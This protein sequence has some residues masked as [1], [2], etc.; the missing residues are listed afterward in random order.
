MLKLRL[1]RTVSIITALSLLFTLLTATIS[2]SAEGITEN[3]I[4]NGD[5]ESMMNDWSPRKGDAIVST[6]D[7]VHSGNFS[8]K[9]SL[10]E[11][12]DVNPFTTQ[13]VKVIPNTEYILSAWVK[14]TGAPAEALIPVD[15]YYVDETGARNYLANHHSWRKV[16]GDMVGSWDGKDAEWHQIHNRFTTAPTCNSLTVFLR[17]YT[18]TV[19]ATVYFDDVSLARTGEPEVASID[20]DQVFYYPDH[21]EDGVATVTV[22]E[23]FEEIASSG[24]VDFAFKDGAAALKT[25]QNTA[26]KNG[27]ASFVYPMS[28]LSQKQHEYTIEAVVK[29]RS[30]AVK[31]NLAAR[32]F[33]YDRP[34]NVTK[35][36]QYIKDG[37]RAYPF[38]S[39]SLVVERDEDLLPISTAGFSVT[40]GGCFTSGEK[41]LAQLD[42]VH[43]QGMMLIVQMYLNML[44]PG[45]SNNEALT[46]EI[47]TAIKDHPALFAYSVMDEPSGRANVSKDDMINTYRI[48]RDI[49][50]AHPVYLTENYNFIWGGKYC[51]ILGIDPYG[52]PETKTAAIKTAAAQEAVNYE[53]PVYSMIQA[54]NNGNY[55]PT[56]N[57]ARLSLFQSVLTGATGLSF[58][59]FLAGKKDEGRDISTTDLWP[60]FTEFNNKDRNLLYDHFVY[61]DT[62]VFNR[63]VDMNKNVWYH[64]FVKDNDIYVIALNSSTAENA[65]SIPLVSYDGSVT[66]SGY[67]AAVYSGGKAETIKGEGSALDVTLKAN[68]AVIY[69][70]T[71]KETT[72]Y[73]KLTE[74]S[75]KEALAAGG[76]S[77]V[78]TVQPLTDL[79]GYDWAK[80]QIEA[81]FKKNI[82]NA[83]AENTYSPAKNITRADFAMFLMRTLGLKSDSTENFADVDEAAYYAKELAIGKALGILNGVGDNKYNPDAEISR[84]DMMTICARGMRYASKLGG[85]GNADDVASFSD[86]ALIADYAL[87]SIAAMVREG[88]VK[89]NADG[90]VNPLGNTTRAEAAVIMHRILIK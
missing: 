45:H 53:K 13:T 33:K 29:D 23:Y 61:G 70:V 55:Y 18:T 65:A 79:A 66:L 74:K 78:I 41:A 32:V 35:D 39:T 52:R 38:F 42:R 58:Y 60:M 12:G 77:G 5:M 87:T 22:N 1:K 6:G 48:I 71:P 43:K 21:E 64:S 30:G 20:T 7:E 76:T 11:G 26:I 44:A 86:A 3:L 59:G 82:V 2:L 81:L 54:F 34:T 90:T 89:G 49:D 14:V 62:A 50:P 19:G 63:S 84:Q 46:K 40:T 73:S 8:M 36:G 85:G 67:Q 56:P 4:K 17:V 88:I 72:D 47:V 25:E 31:K 83:T 9:I 28:L 10:E 51:D 57:E 80:E 27:V 75:Y 37:K 24:T 69:K 15:G 68:T 16:D